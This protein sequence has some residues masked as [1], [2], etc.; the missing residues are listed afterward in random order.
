MAK[1]AGAGGL[2]LVA[3][4]GIR[5]F[6]AVNRGTPEPPLAIGDC[7][8]L[9]INTASTTFAIKRTVCVASTDPSKVNIRIVSYSTTADGRECPVFSF[10]EKSTSTQFCVEFVR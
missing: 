4:I 2:G 9:P 3:M 10:K 1:S 5:V 7:M 6:L 8:K